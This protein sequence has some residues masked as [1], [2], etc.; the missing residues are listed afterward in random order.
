MGMRQYGPMIT[1]QEINVMA[2]LDDDQLHW[3]QVHLENAD[4]HNPILCEQ[5]RLEVSALKD[6]VSTMYKL[7]SSN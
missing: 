4:N 3:I 5:I 1:M 6:A 7:K 2:C